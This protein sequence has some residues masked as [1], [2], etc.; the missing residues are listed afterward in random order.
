MHAQWHRLKIAFKIVYFCLLCAA[1]WFRFVDNSQV[2]LL[3]Q[4]YVKACIYHGTEALCEPQSSKMVE[5]SNPRWDQWLEFLMIPD[6]P[7]SARLCLSICSESKRRNRKVWHGGGKNFWIFERLMVRENGDCLLCCSVHLLSRVT[8]W[9]DAIMRQ[10]SLNRSGK[11]GKKI[12]NRVDCK[13]SEKRW[14]IC[15]CNVCGLKKRIP[16]KICVLIC[17]V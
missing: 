15:F 1:F 17:F 7:R 13:H 12:W 8:L 3:F 9:S 4:I 11:F 6:I 14:I 2:L 16:L 10:F 5:S